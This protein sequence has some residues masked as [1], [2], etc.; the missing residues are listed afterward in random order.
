MTKS[1][2]SLMNLLIE[3]AEQDTNKGHYHNVETISRALLNLSQVVVPGEE[4]VEPQ[5]IAR[6][7][8]WFGRAARD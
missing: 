7:N 3:C 5:N 2:D 4:V 8:K 1:L 6:H